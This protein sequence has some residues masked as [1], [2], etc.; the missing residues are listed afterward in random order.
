M[1]DSYAT[2]VSASV[3]DGFVMEIMIALM[4]KMNRIVLLHLVRLH[5][6]VEFFLC[7]EVLGK[8]IAY[9]TYLKTR[10]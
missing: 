1:L 6:P 2:M 5:I 3:K 7:E 8:C 4:G 10:Y 9:I